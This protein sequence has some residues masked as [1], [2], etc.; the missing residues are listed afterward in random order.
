[1]NLTILSPLTEAGAANN[2][3][4]LAS[5]DHA[6]LARR[7]QLTI[8][9][10]HNL[11]PTVNP[12]TAPSATVGTDTPLAGST[13]N[14]LTSAWSLISGPGQVWFTTPTNIKFSTPGTYTLKLAATNALGEASRTLS[15]TVT[16][17]AMTPIEIWR[18][19]QFGNH[20]NTGT[21]L[22]TAD[23]DTDSTQN[24]LEYA[25]AMNPAVNDQV[26]MS[27]TKAANTLEFIYT[28]NK[29]ATDISYIVE[30]TDD[31]ANWSTAGV[32]SSV[33]LEGATTQQIKALVPAGVTK[34][35]VRLKVTRP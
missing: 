14:A 32:T 8:T 26:P 20:T 25:T 18:Q 13:T 4:R 5:D 22:D 9:F 29:A 24:L 16:G 6:T 3:T 17:T 35:F 7:P 1:M 31:L 28:K 19:T 12:G 23:G 21:G 34:R 15:I 2:F 10:A 30:W 11:L 27:A 33:L